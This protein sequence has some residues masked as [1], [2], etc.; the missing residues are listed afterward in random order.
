MSFQLRHFS[1]GSLELYDWCHGAISRSG[2][3]YLLK[4]QSEDGMYLIRESQSQPGQVCVTAILTLLHPLAPSPSRPC[5]ASL[6]FNCANALIELVSYLNEFCLRVTVHARRL[7][8]WED[9]SLPSHQ[10]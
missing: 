8:W 9:G 5:G 1:A 7:A 6:C 2:A 4:K 10:R 3:D